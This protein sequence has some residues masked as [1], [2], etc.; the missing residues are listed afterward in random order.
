M[1]PPDDASV[2]SEVISR[3]VTSGRRYLRLGGSLLRLS[4]PERAAF[5]RQLGRAAHDIS[6]RDLGILLDEGWRERKT[7]AWLIAVSGRTGFRDR[8]GE[9]LLASEGPYAGQAYCVALATFGTPADAALLAAYLDR[10]LPRPDLHYD[11]GAALGA[12]LLLDRET[13]TDRAARFLTPGGLWQRWTEGPPRKDHSTPDDRREF[14]A[15]L[16]AVVDESAEHYDAVH[17]E[18]GCGCER[19]PLNP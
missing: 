3:Y 10:Y 12:L 17:A 6:T 11:Q 9:L 5:T 14:L 7:A 13:G 15:R 4:A 1:P 19:G 16:C 8:L 18:T 2:R